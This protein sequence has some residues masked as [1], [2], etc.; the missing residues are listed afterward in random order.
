MLVLGISYGC[1]QGV[2]AGVL[3]T[4]VWLSGPAMGMGSPWYELLESS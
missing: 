3:V 1:Q 2:G 4:M